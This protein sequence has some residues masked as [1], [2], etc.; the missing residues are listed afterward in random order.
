MK[1]VI[2]DIEA[3]GLLDSITKI[4]CLSYTVVG[5]WKVMSITTEDEIKAFFNAGYIY[6]GHNIKDYD[7]PA[8]KK[9]YGIKTEELPYIDTLFLSWY[10]FPKLKKYGLDDFGKMLGIEKVK[11]DAAEWQN[12]SVEKAIERCEQD[13]KINAKLWVN[14]EARLKTLYSSEEEMEHLIKYINFKSDCA[15]TQ[16]TNPIKLDIVKAQTLLNQWDAMLE[17][18][19]QALES[20]MP[21]IPKYSL[22]TKPAQLYLKNGQLSV[23]GKDWFDF[24]EKNNIPKDNETPIRYVAKWDYPNANSTEQIK[25]W[26][27]KLGW[28]P[29][30]Y[31]FERNKETGDVKQIPQILTESK[32]VC[33]SILAL[34]D[35]QPNVELLQG[36]G[37]LKH[38][39]GQVKGLLESVDRDGYVIQRIVGLTSTLRM[40]HGVVVNLP[41]VDKP[42]GK[43][44]RGLF[45]ADDNTV[46]F[47]VD[48]KNLESRTKDH[49]ITP[50]DPEYVAEMNDPS[51]D[52]HTDL[53]VLANK[54]TEEEEKFYKW[55]KSQKNK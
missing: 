21:M 5:E 34:I 35:K 22:K 50:Y 42:Y 17:E 46:V 16:S 31:R 18:K 55:Y 29:T 2:F 47:G 7:L 53:A 1:K 49:Y 38:R 4:Y 37:V 13:V 11:I 27:F 48:I 6:V 9:V 39:Y 30:T 10:I 28:Q 23:K 19:R 14:A 24:L 51:F 45:M 25:E 54:I 26:L 33:P 40:K 8:V 12:L 20:V 52:S 15:Y 32:E 3:D 44:I 36:F 43:D 41:G